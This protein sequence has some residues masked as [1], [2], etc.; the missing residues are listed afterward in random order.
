MFRNLDSNSGP[1]KPK[2][3]DDTT[4]PQTLR[5]SDDSI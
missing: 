5:H 2:A 1:T 3:G 4:E